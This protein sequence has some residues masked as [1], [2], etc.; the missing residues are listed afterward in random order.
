MEWILLPKGLPYVDEPHSEWPDSAKFR[1]FTP[2]F[3][4]FGHFEKVQIVFAKVWSLLCPILNAVRQILI[5][6]NEKYI[7]K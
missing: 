7:K 1:H 4:K 2:T 5:V 6:E 3:K